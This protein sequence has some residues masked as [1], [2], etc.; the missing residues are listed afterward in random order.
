MKVFKIIFCLPS[1]GSN[2][3]MNYELHQKNSTDFCKYI[4][5]LNCIKDVLHYK[6]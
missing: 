3:V 4:I 5:S 1:M 2:A 6:E